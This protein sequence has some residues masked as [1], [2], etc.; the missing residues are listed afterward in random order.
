MA[1]LN[2]AA[3][4]PVEI[5]AF[6]EDIPD[7]MMEGEE[8]LYSALKKAGRV[9]TCSTSTGG[10]AGSSYDPSGRPSVRIPMR[11]KAGSTHTQFNADGG[12]MGRGTGSLWADQFLG[13]VSFSQALE[14]TAQAIWSTDS[15]KKARINVKP[16]E[17][18]NTLD[19][20]KMALDADFQGDGSGALATIVTASS[21]GTA[22]PAYSNVTVDN[23]NQF[24]DNQ[25]V[26][27][28]P[29]VGGT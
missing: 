15:S 8:T 25:I 2:E 23:A 19:Q 26:Q 24:F 13:P 17:M 6:R 10:G 21:A 1:A 14:I 28:F 12:D 29:S 7:L 16:V 4:Q 20:F 11:I 5:E 22:G 27:V 18:T 3:V 9:I